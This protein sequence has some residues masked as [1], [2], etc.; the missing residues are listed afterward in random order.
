MG[1]QTARDETLSRISRG[2][3]FADFQRAFH[4][5]RRR[6]LKIAVHLIFGLPGEGGREIEQ[7]M[8]TLA[9]LRPDGVK[10]HNLHVPLG[11]PLARD[12]QRGELTVAGPYRHLEYV[13]PAIELLPP[14]TVIMRLTCDTPVEKLAAPRVFWAKDRFLSA[15]DAQMRSRG[16][17]QGRRFADSGPQP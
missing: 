16:A 7:T 6:G 15:L 4:L 13:I 2:H 17:R 5:V 10:I 3:T 8:T 12:Y 14:E 1:L 11:T 9:A